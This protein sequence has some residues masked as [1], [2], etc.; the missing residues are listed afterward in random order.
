MPE[1]VLVPLAL[2]ASAGCLAW[3]AGS[4]LA[5]RVRRVV[6]PLPTEGSPAGSLRVV[7][8]ARNEADTLPAAA[9]TLLAQELPG[10][11]VIFVDDRSDDGTGAHVDGLAAR[12]PRARAVHVD[13]L[14]DGWLGKTHALHVGSR[15]AAT[16][17]ILFTDADVHFA[18]GTLARAVAA[19]EARGLDHLAV[20]PDVPPGGFLLDAAVAAFGRS[21]VLGQRLWAV[22]DPDSD[23]HV[24]VG[25]FNM[26]RRSAWERTERVPWFARDVIDDVALGRM[27]KSSGARCGVALG[28]RAVSVRWYRSLGEMVRGLEKNTF[29]AAGYSLPKALLLA[30]LLVTVDAGPLLALSGCGLDGAW[31]AALRALGATALVAGLATGVVLARWGGRRVLPALLFPVGTLLVAG[32]IVRAAWL[33]ARRGGIAWRDTFHDTESLREH[34]RVRF[35]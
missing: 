19:A 29:A 1:L 18:P 12:D 34:A 35:L 16:D 27:M 10:L 26:V 30:G 23:A 13:A 9:E 6:P 2:A 28:R 7:V 17:W 3:L 4:A 14:P 8:P 22:E 5:L 15:D 24:G 25:A 33:G 32:M 11:E 31:G 20:L 21:F